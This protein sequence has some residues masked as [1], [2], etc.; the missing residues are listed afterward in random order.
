MMLSYKTNVDVLYNVPSLLIAPQPQIMSY[1]NNE[2]ITLCHEGSLTFNRGLKE[3]ISVI[4]ILRDK[5]KLKIIGDIYG[6]EKKWFNSEVSKRGLS[7]NIEI[8]GWINYRDIG[9]SL[10]GCNAGLILFRE[11]MQNRLSGPPNKLFNYMNAGLPVVSVDFPEMR[12]VI[13]EE[14]CGILI[15]NQSVNAIVEAINQLISN[16]DS[17][18]EMGRSGQKAIREKYCWD[19]MEQYLVSAYEKLEQLL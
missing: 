12:K 8:T 17:I 5:V 9:K 11:C 16:P 6:A 14:K 7:N 2:K 19:K 13:T 18:L 1:L 3:V 4:E 10:H 15:K